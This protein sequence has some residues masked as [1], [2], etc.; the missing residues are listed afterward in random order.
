[1]C[2]D[3]EDLQ[4]NDYISE[5]NLE[6]VDEPNCSED[7]AN[8][9]N[10]GI[11]LNN[12]LFLI[13]FFFV[14]SLGTAPSKKDK[15]LPEK[16]ATKKRKRRILEDGTENR[17]TEVV[18]AAEQGS[19]DDC[20]L[21]AELVARKLKKLDEKTREIAMNDIDNLL[22]RAK[23]GRSNQICQPFIAYPIQSSVGCSSLAHSS[24]PTNC[25]LHFASS[26]AQPISEQQSCPKCTSMST[27]QDSK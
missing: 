13:E 18:N 22:F 12:L 10:S 6:T 1:M 26:N 25:R 9:E 27:N 17:T 14:F 19:K 15:I 2:F 23:M 7:D 3:T 5:Q 8:S 21:F 11:F 20:F 4:E 16:Q 24:F